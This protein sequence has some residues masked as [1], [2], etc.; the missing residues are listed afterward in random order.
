[1]TKPAIYVIVRDG[2]WNH[3]GH[4]TGG[5][6][7]DQVVALGSA[8]TLAYV[9][10]IARFEPAEAGFWP[11]GCDAGALMDFDR[12]VLMVFTN[13][14]DYGQRAVFLEGLTRTW[15]GW[16]IR[17]AY[18]DKEDFAEY[19]GVRP[20]V[21]TDGVH[22]PDLS[23][24]NPADLDELPDDVTVTVADRTG[25]VRAYAVNYA[26]WELGPKIV[27][28][29][30]DDQRCRTV[31][32]MPRLGMHLDLTTATAGFWTGTSRYWQDLRESW[33]YLWPG[34]S[35]QLWDDRWQEQVGRAAGELTLPPVDVVAARVGY[36]ERLDDLWVPFLRESRIDP[37][38]RKRIYEGIHWE[39]MAPVYEPLLRADLSKAEYERLRRL[40]T[41]PAH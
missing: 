16:E 18:A 25:D 28:F 20:S 11:Y 29:L 30:H 31:E 38:W 10:A 39:V 1:M 13:M 35:L 8:V 21:V 5:Y 4:N 2:Q 9:D 7:V 23:A 6:E 27:D 33:P 15:P 3:A 26:P 24:D 36:A 41:T 40:A 19:P 32:R 22:L 17:W 34:W 12:Q 14:L 37:F